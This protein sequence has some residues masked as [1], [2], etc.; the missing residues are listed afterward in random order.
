MIKILNSTIKEMYLKYIN[1]ELPEFSLE[2]DLIE[3]EN[4]NGK[5]YKEKYE[6]TALELI[7]FIDNKIKQ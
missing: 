4:K 7:E 5:E 3:L 2:N 1:N 6:K